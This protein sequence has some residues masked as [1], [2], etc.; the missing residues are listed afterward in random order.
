M[1]RVAKVAPMC[2]CRPRVTGKIKRTQ[3]AKGRMSGEK[4]KTKEVENRLRGRR[5]GNVR[6]CKYRGKRKGS[7][8]G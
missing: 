6:R 7:D 8:E 1:T 2:L 4:M 3:Y 5:N